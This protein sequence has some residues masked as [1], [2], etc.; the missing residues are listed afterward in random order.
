[1]GPE[2]ESEKIIKVFIDSNII[3][4]YIFVNSEL[5]NINGEESA[6]LLSELLY[7]NPK[8]Y[9]SYKT[10]EKLKMLGGIEGY[11]FFISSWA[12]S[13]IQKSVLEDYAVKELKNLLIPIS[14]WE[15]EKYKIIKGINW[16]EIIAATENFEEFM[17]I[18]IVGGI[19]SIGD[20]FDYSELP[21]FI[22]AGNHLSDSFLL[23]QAEKSGCLYFLTADGR[24][25]TILKNCET[26]LLGVN[27][28]YFFKDVVGKE[29]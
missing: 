7:I 8:V 19:I 23:S 27:P 12:V 3:I 21:K 29:N 6:Q 26:N 24:I 22:I 14:F 17:E 9:F 10:I 25:P 4:N 11:E 20:E 2:K 18:Y 15:K 5:K 28:K 16:G 13:E 1:M